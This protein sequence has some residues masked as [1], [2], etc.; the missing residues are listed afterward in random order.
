[1]PAR[2]LRE[3]LLNL[4]W[5]RIG[6]GSFDAAGRSLAG[7]VEWLASELRDAEG[8]DLRIIILTPAILPAQASNRETFRAVGTYSLTRMG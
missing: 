1:M 5:Y 2:W 4:Q 6:H 7:Y 8:T 3:N